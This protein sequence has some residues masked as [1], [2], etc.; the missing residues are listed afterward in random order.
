MT[1]PAKRPPKESS[2]AARAGVRAF[3]LL[4]RATRSLPEHSFLLPRAS[5]PPSPTAH[6]KR[7]RVYA[8]ELY[9][10]LR[11]IWPARY[12]YKLTPEPDK[13]SHPLFDDTELQD[14]NPDL[15]IHEPGT[16]VRDLAVIEVKR[17]DSQFADCL[18]DVE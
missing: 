11:T 7:E 17:G 1:R 13:K 2:D 3:Q 6:I 4:I 10:Q 15:I 9:H 12:P 14:A 16:S 8:Y 5:R 18:E